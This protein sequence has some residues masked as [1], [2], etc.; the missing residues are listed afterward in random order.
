MHIQSQKDELKLK[1]RNELLNLIK[2]NFHYF[3][4]PDKLNMITS[5]I[6][7]HLTVNNKIYSGFSF[8][9]FSLC[10]LTRQFKKVLYD[11]IQLFSDMQWKFLLW[12]ERITWVTPKM[13]HYWL[14]CFG[15]FGPLENF[16][17]IWRRQHYRWMAENVDWC[18]AHSKMSSEDL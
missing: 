7:Q 15:L 9:W 17:V 5:Y 3:D 18:S 2:S 12:F 4:V 14:I 11:K 1:M 8:A 13:Q 10:M 16:S 6:I